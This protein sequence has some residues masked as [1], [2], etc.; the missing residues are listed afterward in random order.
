VI[1]ITINYWAVLVAAVANIIIGSVWYS[2][3]SRQWLQAIGKKKEELSNPQNGYIASIITALITAYVLAYFVGLV[4]ATMVADGAQLGFWIWLGF[5][6]TYT[7]M[8]YA[9]EGRSWNLWLINNG[10]QLLT[11]VVMAG[12]LAVM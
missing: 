9:W 5:V 4:E 1:D 8:A 10:N 7:A 3:F 11:L 2:V 6:G 12:I